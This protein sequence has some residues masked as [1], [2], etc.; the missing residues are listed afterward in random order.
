MHCADH[1]QAKNFNAAAPLMA[2]ISSAKLQLQF[3]K[4]KEA[5]GRWV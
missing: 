4:A 5:E 3:A 2:R 1:P